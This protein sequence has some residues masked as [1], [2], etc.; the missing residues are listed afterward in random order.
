MRSCLCAVAA[1]VASTAKADTPHEPSYMAFISGTCSELIIEGDKRTPQCPDVVVNTAYTDNYSSFRLMASDGLVVSFFGYD[2]EAQGDVAHLTVERLLL[3][4]AGAGGSEGTLAEMTRRAA[5]NTRDLQAF[6]D[7]EYTNP[8][9]PDTHISC[10]AV[11]DGKTY[12]FVFHPT[13]FEVVNL[14][15][16][17]E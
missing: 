2:N 5:A 12:S 8:D 17:I 9:L 11:V 10:H 14:G 13:G 1:L 4:P 3:T 15:G 7:C 6:G 16:L